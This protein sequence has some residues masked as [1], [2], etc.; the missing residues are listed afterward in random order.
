MRRSNIGHPFRQRRVR[1]EHDRI[2]GGIARQQ[3]ACD[4]AGEQ[5]VADPAAGRDQQRA[6]RWHSALLR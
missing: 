4:D 6:L 2:D 1:R 3:R 5:R